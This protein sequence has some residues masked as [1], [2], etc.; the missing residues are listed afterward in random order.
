MGRDVA[1]IFGMLRIP[2]SHIHILGRAP[3]AIARGADADQTSL[4]GDAATPANRHGAPAYLP[5][6]LALPGT[7]PYVTE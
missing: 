4:V 3:N 6:W 7:P 1:V 2:S 5:E